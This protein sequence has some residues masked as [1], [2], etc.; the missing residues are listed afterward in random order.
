MK[1]N[2]GDCFVAR[3]LTV[4]FTLKPR[5]KRSTTYS[6]EHNCSVNRTV[7]IR[8][9]ME[10]VPNAIEESIVCSGDDVSFDVFSENEGEQKNIA[11][12]LAHSLGIKKF[13][14]VE[15]D[16]RPSTI[17]PH[18]Q[19]VST[20]RPS[21]GG[22]PSRSSFPPLT[23]DP[24]LE[25][26][27]ELRALR[28]EVATLRQ[29][30]A[31]LKRELQLAKR[32]PSHDHTHPPAASEPGGTPP[33]SRTVV[34]SGS[35]PSMRIAVSINDSPCAIACDEKF[36]ILERSLA[37][38]REEYLRLHNTLLANQTVMQSTLEIF[39]NN[40][41]NFFVSLDTAHTVP[42]P[43]THGNDE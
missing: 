2:N 24:L 35:P 27:K 8:E 22:G 6:Q 42:L 38:Q 10:A 30:S 28:A 41:R 13:S 37:S 36:A 20:Q 26:M 21:P 43:I 39:K 3:R 17:G 1:E 33:A 32:P 31:A 7:L 14:L 18:H 4:K 12:N 29:E 16:I 15:T 34:N 9:I 5:K 25:A 19:Q 40:L 11:D 23:P